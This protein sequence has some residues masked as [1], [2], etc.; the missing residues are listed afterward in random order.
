M[1]NEEQ[2]NTKELIKSY[3]E[4]N[5]GNKIECRFASGTKCLNNIKN[6]TN[7]LIKKNNDMLK[8]NKNNN[9]N[10][11]EILLINKSNNE[12]NSIINKV[13][14]EEMQQILMKP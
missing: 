8:E 9:K 5:P 13:E 2:V 1:L 12:V 14:N 10:A 7:Y 6:L 3:N 4:D 11:K